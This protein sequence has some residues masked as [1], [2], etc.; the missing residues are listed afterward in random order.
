MKI[1]FGTIIE[2]KTSKGLAYALYTHRHDE[3]PRYGALLRVFDKLYP[4][5]PTDIRTI[6]KEPVQFSVFFPLQAAVNRGI[7]NVVGHT[8]IPEN[9]RPFP[10]F[11]SGMIDP[12]SKEITA[13]WLW[14]GKKEWRI[15]ELTPEQRHFPIR[16]VW[17]DTMLI[18][19]IE[20]GWRP[21]EEQ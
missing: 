20:N 18:N 8:E 15:G 4:S 7:V 6:I 2:I 21:E 19:K 14:D 10:V 3:P 9:L 1:E 17:N 11:R 12:I 5:R 16:A 13:W